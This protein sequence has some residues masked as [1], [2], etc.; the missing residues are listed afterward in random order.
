MWLKIGIEIDTVK[1]SKYHV[2][3]LYIK[4][5]KKLTLKA[6][7]LT[8]PTSKAKP[9]FNNI[10]ETL[11]NIKYVLTF[12][13][14]IEL[15]KIVFEN[16]TLSVMFHRDYLKVT[17]KDYEIIGTVH[18][19]GK[20]LQANIPL[21]YL[22]DH[23]V[24]LGG[25][26]S[27]DLHEDVLITQGRFLYNDVKG[28][29]AATKERDEIE[30]AVKSETFTD[31]RSIINKFNMTD[32]VKSWIV[33]KV[34]AK[35]Y[36]LHALSG[37]GSID[38]GNF[39]LDVASL[40]GEIL[41]RGVKIHFKENVKP[42]IAN[43]FLLNYENGGLYFKLNKP[44]YRGRDLNGSKVAIVNLTDDNTTLQLD[45]KLDT[46]FDETIQDLLKAYN[47]TIPVLQKDG[48]VNATFYADIGLKKDYTYFI[49][50]VNFT[51]GDISIGKVQL[52]IVKGNLH[53][54]N[55]FIALNDIALKNEFYE[56]TINGKIDLENTKADLVFDAKRVQLGAENETFF[57]LENEKLPFVLTYKKD[58]YVGISKLAMRLHSTTK[59]TKLTLKD[60][61]KIKKYLSDSIPIEQGGNIEITTKDFKTYTFKGIMKR[62]TCFLYEASDICKTRVAFSGVITEDDVKFYAF[63]KRLSYSKK[64]S[65]IVLKNLNIDLK[66][67]LDENDK[68]KKKKATKKKSKSSKGKKLL[69]I[70]K[71]SHL[72]YDEYRLITDSYDVEVKP[73]GDINAIGSAAG[74]IIKF[75]KK[76]DVLSMKALRIKD[77]V[78]HPLINFKGLQEGRYSLT[79]KGN[80]EKVMKGQ[81]IVEGGV[82][83]GF[84]AYN[85]ILAFVNTLPALAVLHKPGYSEKGFTIEEG[86]AEYRM[87]NRT[88]V[89]FDSIYI[90]GTSATIVGKGELDL[91]KKTIKMDLAIQVAR[92][93]GKVIGNIPL[94]G[95]ILMGEDKSVTVGLKVSGSLDSP[96]VETTATADILSLP[97]DIIKRTLQTPQHIINQ[98]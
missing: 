34:E 28:K 90:K 40:K 86:V 4:L 88:K 30:F 58:I 2:G 45:L 92:E 5:D 71:N 50:D 91:E 75:T 11:E 49:T 44:R 19:E 52:P 54:E 36:K 37:K 8:I 7:T 87:I 9:S 16:N 6:N 97:L 79:K 21:L 46:P 60:L 95:Y 38:N 72:R 57:F 23:N 13:D 48:K 59:E 35:E 47:L 74:D 41:F 93:F 55:G 12:F 83:K 84:K 63:D 73:N 81:I 82:M 78:L 42:V 31:L 29:F 77:K 24:T 98:K 62:Q 89:I 85:N 96:K 14:L 51:K 26:F 76:K 32:G 3:G 25:K 94:V 66:K 61:S 17:S 20:M 69:I 65:R 27:Y 67:F 43:S 1:L 22:K 56:G 10:P 64:K 70:G 18:R 80:P 39:D 15:K 68:D 53:Y 33:D